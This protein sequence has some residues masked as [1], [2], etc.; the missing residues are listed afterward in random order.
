MKTYTLGLIAI[1]L[2]MTTSCSGSHSNDDDKAAQDS[3][4]LY[5]T[6]EELQQTVAM[7]D[8]LFA[9]INEIG[10]DMSQIRQIEA[11]AAMPANVSG[12]NI[13]KRDQMKSDITAI[14]QALKQRRERLAQLERKLRDSNAQNS[15]MLSTIETL[16]VQI[17]EQE[18][19]IVALKDQLS[20][21]NTTIAGLNVAVDSLKVSEAAERIG[22]EQ[23]QQEAANLT[24]ELNTVYYA[25]G[26]KKELEQHNIIKGGFLRKTKV[27]QG[28][29]QLNYFTRI[30]KRNISQIQLHSRKAKVLT[31]QPA[32]SYEITDGAGGQK[33]LVITNASRFWSAS[34]FLVIQID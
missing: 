34:N 17:A 15:T 25:I 27:M 26:S 9:L 10:A 7:Q 18:K 19:E 13:S 1:S 3:I 8:S 5:Q 29:Y 2:A 21:A 30:D 22:K 32:N 33:V 23:A 31:N 28:D 16:K 6:R 14:S 11:I 4:Q 12:E 20:I 24:N